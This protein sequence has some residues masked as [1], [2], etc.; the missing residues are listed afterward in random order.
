MCPKSY[1]TAESVTLLEEFAIRRRLGG[2]GVAELSARQADAFV[3]LEKTLT[4]ELKNGRQNTREI[5]GDFR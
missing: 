5:V 4:E 3:I 2:M 1:I